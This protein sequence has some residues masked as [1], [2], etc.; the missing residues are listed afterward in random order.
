MWSGGRCWSVVV[1]ASSLVTL[2]AVAWWWGPAAEDLPGSWGMLQNMAEHVVH[3]CSFFL[4]YYF[5][6]F[7]WLE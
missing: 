3:C 6:A 1:V 7:A 2:E 4:L 5:N